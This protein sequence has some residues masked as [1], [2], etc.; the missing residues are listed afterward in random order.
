MSDEKNIFKLASAHSSIN[1]Y[2]YIS[3]LVYS[4][5]KLNDSNAF[6]KIK[7]DAQEYFENLDDDNDG[8]ILQK[9]YNEYIFFKYKFKPPIFKHVTFE[10]I[11]QHNGYIE[12]VVEIMTNDKGEKKSIHYINNNIYKTVYER[13]NE[14]NEDVKT[15]ITFDVKNLNVR[16]ISF[17]LNG[18]LHN[19]TKEV[20]AV[21][22]YYAD[23]H[24]KSEEYY[25]NGKR[26][27]DEWNPA[28]IKYDKFGNVINEEFYMND[29]LHRD[30]DKPALIGYYKSDEVKDGEPHL[31]YEEYR[32]NGKIHRDNKQP[33]IVT[34]DQYSNVTSEEYYMYDI[35]LLLEDIE[36][37]TIDELYFE[38]F[39]KMCVKFI[40]YSSSI[41]LDEIIDVKKHIKLTQKNKY[42]LY[43]VLFKDILN[44]L[45]LH[46]THTSDNLSE[47]QTNMIN[48]VFVLNWTD[49]KMFCIKYMFIHN[50][51]DI[52][53]KY[54]GNKLIVLFNCDR[55]YG[56]YK[57]LR[58]FDTYDI[59]LKHSNFENI[60]YKIDKYNVTV[61]KIPKKIH[62]EKIDN[63]KLIID[64]LVFDFTTIP[65]MYDFESYTF[66]ILQSLYK[67]FITNV[68][69]VLCDE[70]KKYLDKYKVEFKKFLEFYTFHG[71]VCIHNILRDRFWLND[72]EYCKGYT[73]SE[74]IN[75]IKRINYCM[76]DANKSLDK[77]TR[78]RKEN[79][80]FYRGVNLMNTKFNKG[81]IIDNYQTQF[82]SFSRDIEIAN[83]FGTIILVLTLKESD[84][85]FPIE[86]IS[87]YP[88][89]LEWLLPLYTTFIITD[90]PKVFGEK[91]IVNI[92]IYSQNKN[93]GF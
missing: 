5:Y 70:Y 83:S 14:K 11:I 3:E 81:E 53:S 49:F 33:A 32:V 47:Q 79:L 61:R 43:R 89:E 10:T 35:K 78:N 20:P 87:N 34:Y 26:S 85:I 54:Y 25:E 82:Q 7:L 17:Y 56:N 71:D 67:Y 62:V 50:S 69:Y 36:S 75:I 64:S 39:K 55:K 38:V 59:K 23:G 76:W 27:G 66:D 48:L 84:I 2:E 88:Q 24:V 74:I 19:K 90:D 9:Y 13:K 93:I 58:L 60:I 29:I 42:D 31:K 73:N 77:N 16:S 57:V 86:E 1:D 72:V 22:D 37:K 44:T 30:G 91:L 15:E 52:I 8:I 41:T 80:I 4:Q 40:S 6:E 51:Y 68:S 63:L 65:Y 46:Y 45:F 21:I 12:E 18:L 28:T 92:E